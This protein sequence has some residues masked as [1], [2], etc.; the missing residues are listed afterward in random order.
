M[1]HKAKNVYFLSF[2]SKRLPPAV[3]SPERIPSAV[4]ITITVITYNFHPHASLTFWALSLGRDFSFS[5]YV[6]SSCPL[7]KCLRDEG[8]FRLTVSGHC[9]PPWKRPWRCECLNRRWMSHGRWTRKQRAQKQVQPLRPSSSDPP[10]PVR[11]YFREAPRPSKECQKLEL[12]APDM[13]H[14]TC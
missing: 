7:T 11:S 3:L 6:S 9:R 5:R 4:D 8:L 1:A 2:N 10:L 12:S 14:N 13:N